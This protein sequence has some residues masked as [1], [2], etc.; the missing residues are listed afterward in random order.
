MDRNAVQIP[1]R[2]GKVVAQIKPRPGLISFGILSVFLS[3]R[4]FWLVLDEN[5]S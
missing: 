3:N 2:N 5:S 1:M 4:R